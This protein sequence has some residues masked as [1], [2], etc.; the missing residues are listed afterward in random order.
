MFLNQF[1][2][3]VVQIILFAIIPFV[4]WLITARKK[5]N[6]FAW[7][8]LKK[9]VF[10]GKGNGIVLLVV[11]FIAVMALGQIAIYFRGEM[12]AADSAYKGMG[13]VAIPSILVYAFGQT[14]FSEEVLFRGFLL[15]RLANKLGFMSANI[16]T[17]AV[18]GVIHLTMVWG[19]VNI[20]SGTLIV[21]YPAVVALVFGWLN[22][23]KFKGSILP[24][25]IIHGLV[26]TVESC[27]QAFM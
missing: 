12:E 17:A 11:S 6:F 23:K 14:A 15:K 13:A 19:H 7:I 1:F 4:W 10:E 27:L 2:N 24:S 20:L 25:W 18:F 22:E 5:E 26:N 8:G 16:I 9:P 21:V 3:A